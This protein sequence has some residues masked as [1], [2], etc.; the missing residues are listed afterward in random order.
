M[1]DGRNKRRKIISKDLIGTIA[2]SEAGPPMHLRDI[3][4]SIN[5]GGPET[6]A[7]RQPQVLAT[8]GLG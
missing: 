4:W 8:V 7:R 1:P 3:S 2:G 6:V 5:R